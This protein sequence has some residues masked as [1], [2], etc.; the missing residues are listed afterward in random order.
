MCITSQTPH[1]LKN[2]NTTYKYVSILFIISYSQA[3][4]MNLITSQLC[5]TRQHMAGF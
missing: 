4:M 1:E 2:G 3:K 5:G